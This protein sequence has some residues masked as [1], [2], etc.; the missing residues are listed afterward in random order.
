MNND[1]QQEYVNLQIGLVQDKYMNIHGNKIQN[2]GQNTVSD[3]IFD[4]P[5]MLIFYMLTYWGNCGFWS[6]SIGYTC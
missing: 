6:I 3:N 1:E 2:L 5:K 4:L